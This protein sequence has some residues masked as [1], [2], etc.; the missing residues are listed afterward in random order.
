MTLASPDAGL[1]AEQLAA[2]SAFGG[3]GF[4]GSGGQCGVITALAMLQG[5][6]SW[7]SP[8]DKASVYSAVRSWRNRFHER[9]GH[10]DCRELKANKKPCTELIAEGIR[11]WNE[12]NE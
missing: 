10:T 5:L 1:T 2:L 9:F 12:R 8:S 3:G 7:Q 4:G 6:E 11:L